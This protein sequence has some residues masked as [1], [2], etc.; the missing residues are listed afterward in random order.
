[1]KTMKTMKKIGLAIF[2]GIILAGLA[3]CSPKRGMENVRN[4]FPKAEIS[5]IPSH[6]YEFIVRDVDG[7]VIYVC[8]FGGSVKGENDTLCTSILLFH[9]RE[10]IEK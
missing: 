3:G 10:R 2:L 1:M 7:S 5:C 8:E 4:K 9:G 6:P